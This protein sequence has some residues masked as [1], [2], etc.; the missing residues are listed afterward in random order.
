LGKLICYR[1]NWWFYNGKILHNGVHEAPQFFYR[2]MLYWEYI[3]IY[4]TT[5]S[6]ECLVPSSCLFKYKQTMKGKK[7]LVL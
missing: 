7:S 5:R 6:T 4:T 1:Y 3:L 2:A